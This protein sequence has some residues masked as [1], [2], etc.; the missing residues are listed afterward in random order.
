MQTVCSTCGCRNN[1]ISWQRMRWWSQWLSYDVDS[2]RIYISWHI[3][4]T[5]LYYQI[6][7][8]VCAENQG[9]AT[10]WG[11][12]MVCLLAFHVHF[13]NCHGFPQNL[14]NMNRCLQGD[15][16]TPPAQPPPWPLPPKIII[17]IIIIIITHHHHHHHSITIIII[18]TIV[19]PSSSSSSPSSSSSSP[20]SSSSS[21]LHQYQ[22][23]HY[24]Q[25]RQQHYIGIISVSII[26]A[27]VIIS[28]IISLYCELL[29]QPND[30]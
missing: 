4:T 28:I 24:H 6:V 9:F 23:R 3:L 2:L 30:L 14:T 21:A 17:I 10:G 22:H 18:I 5:S 27:V 20:S 1:W 16:L 25:N 13:L 11:L 26:I 12:F 19:S 15:S 7:Y 8:S 29:L